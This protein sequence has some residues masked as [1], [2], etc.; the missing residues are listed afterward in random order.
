MK[1]IKMENE[2]SNAFSMFFLRKKS[3]L[4]IDFFENPNGTFPHWF[5][6]YSNFLN[7]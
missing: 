7:V 4:D 1:T 5:W 2:Y 6:F 3:L